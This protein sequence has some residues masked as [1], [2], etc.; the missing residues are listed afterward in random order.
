MI[1]NHAAYK[2]ETPYKGPFVIT[3][4]WTNGTVTLQYGPTKI[5]Y[6]I[7][8]NNPYTSDTN[9]E[10]ITPENMYDD[11]RIWSPVIYFRITLKLE[12]KLYNK[13]ITEILALINLG[14]ARDFFMM[15]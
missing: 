8:R 10:D 1:N 4:C 14:H 9:N 15:M 3:Q 2:Y 7:G 11:V 12:N 5:R 6:N 13:M